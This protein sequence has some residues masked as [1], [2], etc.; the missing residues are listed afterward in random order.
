MRQLIN[1][2]L[3]GNYSL[4]NGYYW[5]NGDVFTDGTN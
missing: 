2:D 1:N 3:A 4:F 5:Y